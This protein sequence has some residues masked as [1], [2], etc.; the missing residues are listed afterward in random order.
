MKENFN[1]NFNLFSMNIGDSKYKSNYT[2]VMQ[3]SK[4]STFFYIQRTST[5]YGPLV[6]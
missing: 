3:N 6:V 5:S 4:H 2:N 1:F